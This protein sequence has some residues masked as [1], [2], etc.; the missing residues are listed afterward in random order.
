[1]V[2]SDTDRLAALLQV[3]G[4]GDLGIRKIRQGDRIEINLWAFERILAHIDRERTKAFE[5]GG[6]HAMQF[7]ARKMA[8]AAVSVAIEKVK[9][10]LRE[11]AAHQ[12]R[13]ADYAPGYC[14]ENMLAVIDASAA[15]AKEG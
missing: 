2:V 8:A 15:D 13:G 1:M 11:Y 7:G 10:D 9:A 14:L 3:A 4:Y 12:E 6:I 5:A